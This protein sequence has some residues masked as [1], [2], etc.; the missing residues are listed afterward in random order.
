MGTILLFAVGGESGS[1]VTGAGRMALGGSLLIAVGD[2]VAIGRIG[3]MTILEALR[4]IFCVAAV[5]VSSPETGLEASAD[6]AASGIGLGA[7]TLRRIARGGPP[8]VLV[9]GGGGV[10]SG[11]AG[12]SGAGGRTGGSGAA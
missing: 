11:G 9:S 7:T 6:G 2:A 4:L 5:E 1:A 3:W 10:C 8:G 12:G